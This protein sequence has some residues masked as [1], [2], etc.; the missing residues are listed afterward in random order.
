MFTT[1]YTCVRKRVQILFTRIFFCE[2][3]LWLLLIFLGVF[4]MAEGQ[5][6]YTWNQSGTASWI[7]STNWNPSRTTP[8]VNDILVF[9]NGAST[10]ATNIPNESVGQLLISGNTTVNLQSASG[11]TTLT[12]GD[13]TGVDLSVATGSALNLNSV[14]NVTTLSLVAGATGVVS[15]NIT[16]SGNNHRILVATTGALVFNSPSVFT[17]DIGFNGDVFGTT[18]PQNVAVFNSG[19]TFIQTS[20][21]APFGLTQPQTK[22]TFNTGS[23][24]VFQYM[25][26]SPSLS[27]RTYGDFQFKGSG[28]ASSN[29]GTTAFNIDNL[30][31]TSGTMNINMPVIAGNNIRGNVSVAS[32]A[33]L[34]F[35]P[36]STGGL[37][38]AGTSVQ[39]ISNSGTINFSSTQNITVNNSAGVVINAPLTVLGTLTLSSGIVTTTSTNL[40]TMGAGSVVTG[41]SNSGFIDGP[42]KK[43]GNTDFIFPC[44]K[45]GTGYVPAEIRNF[46]GEPVTT[47]FTA[48]YKRGN[49]EAFGA[50]TAV[51]LKRVSRNDYWVIDNSGGGSPTV[52]LRLYWTTESSNGGSAGF[53]TNLADLVVAHY[54]AVNWNSYGATSTATGSVVAGYV[55]WPGVNVFSPF[56]LGSISFANPLPISVNYFT[57]IKQNAEHLLEWKLNCSNNGNFTIELQ[58]SIDGRNYNGIYS[59]DATALQC[60]QPFSYTDSHPVAGANY[61]RLKIKDAAGKIFYSTV[62]S[63]LHADRGFAILNIAPNPVSNG[64]VDLKISTAQNSKIEIVITDMQGRIMQQQAASLNAGFNTVPVDVSAFSPGIYQVLAN[65]AGERSKSIRLLIR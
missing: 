37:N 32:G 47:A 36:A 1:T 4:F 33:T 27:G 48:E 14:T 52:D 3:R 51:G 45:T 49:A 39:T 7:V 40:L 2:Q 6:T 18:L 12:I 59:L 41:A 62:V 55:V 30:I 60:R 19:T 50:I 8:L 44:G 38:L 20:G 65:S 23:L 46:S 15:G 31:I 29:T 9:N 22:V 42:V 25:S 61:Y 35:N 21:S 57:G 28:A 64:R 58:H 53:I 24:Y 17:Q 43:A 10:T 26:N 16:V 63:L 11:G 54:N 5:S 34:S 56:A 13:G